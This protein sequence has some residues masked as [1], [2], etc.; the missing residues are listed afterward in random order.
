[1][2]R[3]N[4]LLTVISCLMIFTLDSK[5]KVLQAVSKATMYF[6]ILFRL[7][8]KPLHRKM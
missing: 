6:R 8:L 5:T 3:W 2:S 1:V 4:L 7:Q